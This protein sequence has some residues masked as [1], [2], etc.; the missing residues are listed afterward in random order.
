MAGGAF[1]KDKRQGI[2]LEKCKKLPARNLES[3]KN[4]H[5]LGFPDC[6]KSDAQTPIF[7]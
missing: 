4:Q 2:S 1:Q 7:V 5:S 3:P 6:I